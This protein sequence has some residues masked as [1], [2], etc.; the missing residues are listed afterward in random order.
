MF[1]YFMNAIKILGLFAVIILVV[2]FLFWP[3]QNNREGDRI[4]VRY[5]Y[6]T[7]QK[8]ELPFTV[9]LFNEMQDSIFV[10]AVA[11]PWQESEKKILTAILSGDPPDIV[12][13]FAPVVKWASR[14]GLY[15]LD[16]FIAADQFDSTVI[17]PAC[18]QEMQWQGNVFAMPTATAS[19]ALFYNKEMFRQAGLDP[20][21]P[22]RTWDEVRQ[23][24]RQLVRRNEKGHITRMGFLF[25]LGRTL[26]VSQQSEEPLL[27]MAWQK[28]APFT[29]PQKEKVLF[30]NEQMVELLNYVLE[31]NQ[32]VPLRDQL[33]FVAGFG[34]GDQHAF[35]SGRLAMMILPGNFPDHI[36]AYRPGLDYGVSIIPSFEGLPT[37]SST[38]TWWMAIPR[39]A[40]HPRAA[41]EF[42]KFV[43]DKE[44]QLQTLQAMDETLFP[45]NRLA[46]MD[47]S[48]LYKDYNQIFLEQL[49]YAHS[50]TLV[51]LAHDTFWR[52]FTN[53][54]ER[55][56]HGKQQAWDAL[57][58]AELII[59]NELNRAV[60]YDHYVREHMQFPGIAQ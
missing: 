23:Y 45:A 21:K 57:K 11:I 31:A 24:A 42:I 2:A 43:I 19:Y 36:A 39:G 34:Y 5:W 49:N 1:N 41:W 32:D 56:V 58:Q 28:Q 15:P 46:A 29:D 3:Q 18:W 44:V 10:E 53:A 40:K 20:E 9:R 6:A 59:Q 47:A 30:A 55:V 54:I 27:L 14:M 4:H 33:A 48:F 25:H 16:E 35:T 13:H 50:T 12:D 8:E 22:P 51:P 7:G 37:A 26:K 17:F 38:A 52:E 60:A